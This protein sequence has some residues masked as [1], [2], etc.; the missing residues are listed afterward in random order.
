MNFGKFALVAA[1]Y[2]YFLRDLGLVVQLAIIGWTWYFTGGKE[3]FRIFRQTWR[4]DSR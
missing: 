3:W 2:L 1:A 4:R